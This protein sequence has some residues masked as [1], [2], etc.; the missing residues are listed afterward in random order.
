MSDPI[1]PAE[2]NPP[3]G[4]TPSPKPARRCCNW[5]RVRVYTW[6]ILI[7]AG[8]WFC[9]VEFVVRFYP[10]VAVDHMLAQLPFPSTTGK[11]YWINRRTLSI[12]DLKIGDFFYAE[13]VIVTASP[14]GL[15]RHHIAK[16]QILGGQLFTKPLY[17]AMEKAGPGSGKGIDWVIGRLEISRGTLMLNNLLA[18]TSIPVRLGV[19][20]PIILRALRLGA[21]DSS[22][23]MDVEQTV[24]IGQVNI[25]SP[26]DPLSP[27]FA[28]PLTRVRF[29]YTELWHHHIRGIEMIKPTMFLGEDLFWLAREF[30][31]QRKPDTT[32]GPEAPWLF[33][34]FVVQYGQVAVNVFGQPAVHF[35]FYFDTQVN[36]IRLDQLDKISAKAK[37]PIREFSHN[38]PDYKVRIVNLSGDLAFNL[39]VT[40]ANANNVSNTIYIDELSWN[41]IPATKVWTSL[42]FDPNGVYGKMGGTCEGGEVTGNFEFYYSKG[43][44]W[45]ANLF[46]DK[47]NC[48]PIAEK[49]VGKYVNLTGELDGEI[50]VKGKATEILLC[51]GQLALPNPGSLEIKSMKDLLDRIP[52][53]MI[54]V[55]RDALK[56]AI[57]AFQTYPYDQGELKLDYTAAGGTG[58]LKLNGPRGLRQFEAYLHPWSPTDSSH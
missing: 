24:E 2:P 9:A 15:Y 46:A 44:T 53:D 7:C 38:Y 34:H 20:Y 19:R 58:V 39:P 26:F 8:M 29:S 37:I 54:A 5:H 47:I 1:P 6:S 42:T 18:D 14:F 36:D 41:N 32:K 52:S 10:K 31:A 4:E 16:V 21:P 25:V 40:D 56:I 28:F 3:A 27:V 49:L 33:S 23:D 51:K 45:N 48:Q 55:K 57:N 50:N 43:F 12:H 22:P 35:P 11:V 13:R 30:K 17:A